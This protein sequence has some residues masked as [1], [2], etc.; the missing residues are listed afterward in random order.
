MPSPFIPDKPTFLPTYSLQ[1]LTYMP[2]CEHNNLFTVKF[3]FDGL[4]NT[5]GIKP[6]TSRDEYNAMVT[7]LG[8][9]IMDTARAPLK[10]NQR[11][12]QVKVL[13]IEGITPQSVDSFR[14]LQS[15]DGNS[16]DGNSFQCTFVE[17]KKCCARD[18]PQGAGSPA[19]YCTSIGCNISYCRRVRFD[20]VAE[21]LL[22][23]GCDG[24]LQSIMDPSTQRIVNE[25]YNTITQYLIQ[26][27]DSGAFTNSLRANVRYC[28]ALCLQAM[29]D[30]TVTGVVFGPPMD[31]LIAI[32][33]LAPTRFPTSPTPRPTS[34]PIPTPKPNTEP[35]TE[36]PTLYPTRNPTLFPTGSIPTTYPTAET[37]PTLFPTLYP[38][39]NPTMSTL[40][41]TDEPT[42]EPTRNPSP[43]PTL[44]LFPTLEPTRDSTNEPTRIPTLEPEPTYEPTLE[45]EPTYEPTLEPEPTFAPTGGSTLSPSLKPTIA[46]TVLTVLPTILPTQSPTTSPTVSP[47]VSD[48]ISPTQ[49]PTVSPTV[50]PTQ[51]PTIS[52]TV[53]PT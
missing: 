1:Q 51:S 43:L 6:P 35:R 31:I 10:N 37:P 45:P 8:Q 40:F 4:M 13:E 44:I 46:P 48:I 36:E 53:S 41:L 14:Q 50:S 9:T 32:P 5:Y 29:A 12:I 2:T 19:Q 27:V 17:R 21:Q 22:D 11:I 16:F 52:P 30:V 20:I 3:T 25:L 38:T 28:N 47:T 33:T 18:P 7:V 26:Q 34:R 49:S 23:Q 24:K 15:V 39:L 42:M